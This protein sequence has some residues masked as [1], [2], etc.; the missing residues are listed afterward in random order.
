MNN[1][2]S[3]AVEP[4]KGPLAKEDTDGGTLKSLKVAYRGRRAKMF[5]L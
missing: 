4:M 3:V 2:T 5:K 1:R